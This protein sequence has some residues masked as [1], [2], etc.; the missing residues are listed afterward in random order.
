[1]SADFVR[2]AQSV[3]KYTQRTDYSSV[4]YHTNGTHTLNISSSITNVTSERAD[5]INNWIAR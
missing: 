4:L 1:M 5:M 2:L 3:S